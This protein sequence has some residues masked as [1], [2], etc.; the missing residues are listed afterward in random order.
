MKKEMLK[1]RTRF[2]KALGDDTRQEIMRLL[3]ER[4]RLCVNELCELLETISQPTVS[5]HLQIL[6]NSDIVDTEREG[7]MIYYQI[8]HTVVDGVG[9]SFFFEMRIERTP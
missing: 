7:K 3:I 8:N 9:R 5:H 1:E 6:K 4:R 2:F